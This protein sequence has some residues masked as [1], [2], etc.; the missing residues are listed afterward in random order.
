[1]MDK[2][3]SDQEEEEEE[4]EDPPPPPGGPPAGGG[5]PPPPR[6]SYRPGVTPSSRRAAPGAS[7]S[8]R[9]AP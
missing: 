7:A 3:R 1:M 4:E 5:P 9:P 2:M 6:G 8:D